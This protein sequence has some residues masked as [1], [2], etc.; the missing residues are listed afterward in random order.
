MK[1]I[2]FL[3]L[4]IGGLILFVYYGKD[5]ENEII[6]NKAQNV[7]N[8][9]TVVKIIDGYEKVNAETKEYELYRKLRMEQNNTIQERDILKEYIAY[10]TFSNKAKELGLEISPA[11]MALISD[12]AN[13]FTASIK[14]ASISLKP[15]SLNINEGKELISSLKDVSVNNELASKFEE[16]LKKD[17]TGSDFTSYLEELKENMLK[18]WQKSF[19]DG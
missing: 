2:L 10:K 13:N 12:Q 9:E 3:L 8:D 11:E 1:K 7:L 17:F 4:V 19:Q 14:D 16:R 18:E 15:E 5:S 6:R